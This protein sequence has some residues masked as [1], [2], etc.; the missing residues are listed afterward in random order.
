MR[1]RRAKV[2]VLKNQYQDSLL[3]QKLSVTDI[4]GPKAVVGP[5]VFSRVGYYL[6]KDD[7]W[8]EYQLSSG[9]F[10]SVRQ[11]GG[12][13][14]EA[15]QYDLELLRTDL[16]YG[17]DLAAVRRLNRRGVRI[18][19]ELGQRLHTTETILSTKRMMRDI[20]LRWLRFQKKEFTTT[21]D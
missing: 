21:S 17:E 19:E 12:G 18:G 15:F 20:N 9:E 16:L 10:V 14:R 4:H 5:P 11:F 2:K 1:E 6:T 13:L 8:Y 7:V 3:W